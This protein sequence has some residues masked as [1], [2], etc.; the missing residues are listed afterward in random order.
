MLFGIKILLFESENEQKAET[1]DNILPENPT[2]IKG[3]TFEPLLLGE[4]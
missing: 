2:K 1:F 3:T 4:K